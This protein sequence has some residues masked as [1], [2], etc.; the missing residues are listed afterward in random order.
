MLPI[1]LSFR[2]AEADY[3]DF[4]HYH[5]TKGRGRRSLVNVGLMVAGLGVL[6][7]WMSPEPFPYNLLSAVLPVLVFGVVWLLMIRW[8]T[9]RNLKM[10]LDSSPQFWEQREIEITE[11]GMEIHAETFNTDYLWKGVQKMVETPESFLI[12]N[13]PYSAVILPKRAFTAEQLEAFRPIVQKSVN[14]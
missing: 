2:Y 10:A 9:R 12:Y 11:E 1:H 3:Q 8:L 4:I 14:G 7:A 5:L 13:N 6:Y